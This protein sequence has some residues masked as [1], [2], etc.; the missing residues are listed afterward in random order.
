MSTQTMAT[1]PDP[2]CQKCHEQWENECESIRAHMAYWRKLGIPQ[3]INLPPAP[4]Y[5]YHGI[6]RDYYDGIVEAMVFN[7]PQRRGPQ[8]PRSPQ[9]GPNLFGFFS[10]DRSASRCHDLLTRRPPFLV[11]PYRKRPLQFP[12]ESQLDVGCSSVRHADLALATHALANKVG[13]KDVSSSFPRGGLGHA[14]HL[15]MQLMQFRPAAAELFTAAPASPGAQHALSVAIPCSSWSRISGASG[16]LPPHCVS[17]PIK[18]AHL[19]ELARGFTRHIRQENGRRHCKLTRARM[20]IEGIPNNICPHLPGLRTSH[21]RQLQNPDCLH[22]KEDVMNYQA[23]V[24]ARNYASNQVFVLQSPTN[25]TRSSC[26]QLSAKVWHPHPTSLVK[27]LKCQILTNSVGNSARQPAR[28]RQITTSR[29]GVHCELLARLARRYPD[30]QAVAGMLEACSRPLD[31]AQLFQHL[32]VAGSNPYCKL[33][34][35]MPPSECT[36]KEAVKSGAICEIN[37]S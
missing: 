8:P 28:C 17:A 21:D 26:L 34:Q 32:Q 13:L 6:P 16:F 37:L 27:R 29:E 19:R 25:S 7:T 5:C 2:P 9:A 23:Q 33:L 36:K 30:E 18:G 3:A 31:R 1:N 4:R 15:E 35:T 11:H 12:V 10:S 20:L 22:T 24:L 14:V